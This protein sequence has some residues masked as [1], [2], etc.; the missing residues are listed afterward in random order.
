MDYKILPLAI[1]QVDWRT[2]ID[3]TTKVLGYNPTK[4]LGSTIIQ[5]ETPAAYLATLDF[6]NQPLKQ[7]RQGIFLNNTFDH[8]S[9]SFITELDANSLQL[10]MMNLPILDYIIK[11]ARDTYLVIISAKMSIWYPAII[12][13]L[14]KRQ[15]IE[16][17]QIFQIIL[18]WFDNIGFKDIWSNHQRIIL[19]DGS[20]IL[21]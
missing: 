10:V 5:L 18:I 2:Y 15:E 20:I 3:F 12:K 14:S 8:L 13:A 9:V 6:E 11:K 16:V 19:K 21:K 7:L 4:G 1:T 17:R